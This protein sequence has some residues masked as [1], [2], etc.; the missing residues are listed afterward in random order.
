M[1]YVLSVRWDWQVAAARDWLRQLEGTAPFE[2]A[3]RRAGVTS[4]DEDEEDV[5][6]NGESGGPTDDHDMN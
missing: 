6:G 2:A 3:R 4:L 5:G 1:F